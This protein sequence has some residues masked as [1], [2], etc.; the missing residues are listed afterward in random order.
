MCLL[1]CLCVC[2]LLFHLGGESV[3]LVGNVVS[4]LCLPCCFRLQRILRLC[5]LTKEFLF[6]QSFLKVG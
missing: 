6:M 4:V 1:V 3:S 5:Q 2:L